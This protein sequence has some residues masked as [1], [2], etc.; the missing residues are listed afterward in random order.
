MA[1]R[2]PLFGPHTWP[3]QNRETT[4]FSWLARVLA[5]TRRLFAYVTIRRRERSLRL[6]ESLSLGDR[7][8]LA[9]VECEGQ[10]FLI[11]VTS[12]GVTLLQRWR[13]DQSPLDNSFEAA[14]GEPN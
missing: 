7:R 11:G 1:W 10:R 14:A 6:R 5:S 9:L 3:A 12:H 13:K 2:N 8:L 4:G